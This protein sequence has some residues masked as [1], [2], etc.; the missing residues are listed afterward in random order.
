M[1]HLSI[2]FA[3]LPRTIMRNNL[4]LARYQL[5][6]VSPKDWMLTSS[7]RNRQSSQVP[8]GDDQALRE[9]LLPKRAYRSYLCREAAVCG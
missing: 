6:G 3:P 9:R 5:E 8:S 7:N 1:W 2:N 4:F